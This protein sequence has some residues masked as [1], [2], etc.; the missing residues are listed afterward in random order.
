MSKQLRRSQSAADGPADT[1]TIS[2]SSEESEVQ[3]AASGG[4]FQRRRLRRGSSTKM[5]P[6]SVEHV[7]HEAL[8]LR[9]RAVSP[10]S[11]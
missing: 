4:W 6:Q 10:R 3:R 11:L 7:E 1:A 8:P 2:G 9:G 5:P